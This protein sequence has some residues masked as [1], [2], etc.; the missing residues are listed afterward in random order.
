[1]S[2]RDAQPVG[3][4]AVHPRSVSQA[5]MR[6]HN[7]GLVLR[8]IRDH[9]GCSRS[10]L[11][12]ASGLTKA[13]IT[14]LV[15]E[16]VRQRLVAELGPREVSDHAPAQR[17]RPAGPLGLA[18]NHLVGIGVELRIDHVQAIVVDLSGELLGEARLPLRRHPSPR[19]AT[20]RIGRVVASAMHQAGRPSVFGVGMAIG[21]TMDLEG[22]VVIESSWLGWMDVP[23]HDLV[24][25]ELGSDLGPLTI[26]HAAL[27]SG[28]GTSRVVDCGGSG[29]LL[30][31]EV[32]G[33]A[34][35][36]II[37]DGRLVEPARKGAIGH[38]PVRVG[39]RRCGCGKRG[40]LDT[41][42]GFGA[43]LRAMGGDEE[44]TTEVDHN[45]YARMVRARAEQGDRLAMR[46]IDA[47]GAEA[48]RAIAIIL[49]LTNPDRITIGGYLLELGPR[50]LQAARAELARHSYPPT[51]PL[52]EFEPTP[53]GLRSAVVGAAALAVEPVFQ[54]PTLVFDTVPVRH[55]A[56]AAT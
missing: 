2:N 48:G 12:T 34:G 38:I 8:Y 18:G 9:R 22:K 27:L 3:R 46:A 11:A 50:F 51:A 31:F 20:R 7:L 16:L 35:I 53:L 14:K 5:D 45:A 23:I 4:R 21:A 13:G 56:R 1:M 52:H 49:S 30:H 54:D 39:G 40:C 55:R 17:G 42:I 28:L 19:S 47:I 10:D 44:K 37:E 36:G 15:G 24:S 43:L 33:G 32:G 6:A 41:V 26:V 25:A 29:T